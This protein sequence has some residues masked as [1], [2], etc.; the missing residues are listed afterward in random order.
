[1]L[2][3]ILN[4]YLDPDAKVFL[5]REQLPT[6]EIPHLSERMKANSYF[7]GHPIW[8][9][10]YFETSHRHDIFRDRWLAATGTWDRKVVVDIGCGPGN[11][12]ATIGG[13][14]QVLIGVDISPGAL[15]M[16][17]QIGYTPLLADAQHLPLADGCADLVVANATIHHCDDMAKVLA[18]AARLVKPGGLLVTDKDAQSGALHLRGFGLFLREIRFFFYWSMRS[19]YYLSEEYR[20]ARQATETHNQN[21][22]DG[23]TPEVYY[24]ILEPLGFEVKLFPHNHDL[25]IEVLAGQIGRM[26]WK[27]RLVQRL[28]GIDPDTP[29]AAQSIMCVAKRTV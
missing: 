14:P 1:M 7:F 3:S 6:C 19:K 10:E 28:S 21:P 29:A 22:G 13:S 23:I 5:D 24:Q 12:Y 20:N 15:K 16:A 8:G 4:P 2:I 25:G 9:K 26:S 17:R 18:E 11:L 27:R